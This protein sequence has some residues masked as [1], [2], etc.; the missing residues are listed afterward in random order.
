[1]GALNG[2][3]KERQFNMLDKKEER[4]V[5]VIRDGVECLINVKVRAQSTFPLT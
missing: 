1:M 3:Q 4:G 5:K 2:W